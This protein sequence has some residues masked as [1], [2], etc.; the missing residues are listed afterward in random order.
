MVTSHSRADAHIRTDPSTPNSAAA[1]EAPPKP[2]STANNMKISAGTH[3]SGA[4]RGHA[5]NRTS[6]V[7]DRYLRKP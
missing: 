3:T 5:F 7:P 6:C 2:A 1:Y 4:Q